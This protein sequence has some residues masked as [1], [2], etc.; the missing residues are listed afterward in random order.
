MTAC[1]CRRAASAAAPAVTA[2][3]SLRGAHEGAAGGAGQ[4]AHDGAGGGAGQAAHDGSAGGGGAGQAAHSAH[5]S[6]SAHGSQTAAAA[7]ADDGHATASAAGT[8]AASSADEDERA[9]S[10]VP[11][12][13]IVV[14][15]A[16]VAVYVMTAAIAN[17]STV[18]F[19]DTA[20]SA[21][22]GAM[23]PATG[24]AEQLKSRRVAQEQAVGGRAGAQVARFAVGTVAAKDTLR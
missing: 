22:S 5:T 2:A 14:H 19:Q 7:A 9:P 10:G 21:A 24:Q 8:A 11:P 1:T 13:S 17:S 18:R 16:V 3:G 23:L 15:L 4:A 12:T 20:P 6:H